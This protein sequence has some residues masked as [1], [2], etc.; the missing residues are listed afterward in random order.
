V[1]ELLGVHLKVVEVAEL[2]VGP[3]GLHALLDSPAEARRSATFARRVQEA[4][5]RPA[6]EADDDPP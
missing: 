1:G 6:G 2:A 4:L 3:N 5:E